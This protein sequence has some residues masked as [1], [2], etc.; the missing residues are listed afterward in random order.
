MN[1]HS[2]WRSLRFI[3]CP[4]CGGHDTR[5]RD[6]PGGIEV[7]C[8]DC[9][10]RAVLP[11]TPE[12]AAQFESALSR[13]RRGAANAG[14]AVDAAQAAIAESNARIA[15]PERSR[16]RYTQAELLAQCEPNAPRSEEE[17]AWLDARPVGREFGAV[18]VLPLSRVRRDLNSIMRRRETVIVT[19]RRESMAKLEPIV[20]IEQMN[21]AI[22]RQGASAGVISHV[23]ADT[24]ERKR[25]GGASALSSMPDVGEDSDFKRHLDY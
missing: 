8:C 1:T 7:A 15:N 19:R 14:A 18:R 10:W 25:E 4:Q 12:R 2:D 16:P 11:M 13:A 5:T 9:A 17:Q 24:I 21:E 22:R 23:E 3:D 20:T 6:A